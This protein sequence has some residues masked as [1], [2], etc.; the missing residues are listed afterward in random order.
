MGLSTLGSAALRVVDLEAV[1][2]RDDGA[3]TAA[4]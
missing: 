4:E 1:T 2:A 3:W